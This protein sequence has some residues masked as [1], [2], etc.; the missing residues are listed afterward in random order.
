MFICTFSDVTGTMNTQLHQVI[1]L[2]NTQQ[3]HSSSL[4]TSSHQIHHIHSSEAVS[5]SENTVL[6]STPHHHATNALLGRAGTTVGVLTGSTGPVHHPSLTNNPLLQLA[7]VMSAGAVVNSQ[8]AA[9]SPLF[10]LPPQ[11]Q[12]FVATTTQQQQIQQQTTSVNSSFEVR[13]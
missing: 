10:T 4:P 5:V 1:D 11:Y 7:E 9:A 12:H 13:F 6:V 8:T 2:Q 3:D